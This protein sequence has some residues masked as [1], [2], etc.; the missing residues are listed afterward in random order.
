VEAG[1]GGAA[2]AADLLRDVDSDEGRARMRRAAVALQR[3]V[4]EGPKKPVARRADELSKIFVDAQ[5]GARYAGNERCLRCHRAYGEEGRG[6]LF[7][8]YALSPRILVNARRGCEGC[9]G[10]GSKHVDGTIEA[11]TNPR[12]LTKQGQADLCFSCHTVAMLAGDRELHFPG[13]GSNHV[14]CLNCHRVHSPA[15]EKNLREEPNRLCMKCHQD[16][17]AEFGLRSRHPVRPEEP[18]PLFSV[19]EGKVRCIDCHRAYSRRRDPTG[20]EP[21]VE[22]CQGCHA[23]TRGPFLFSHDA[24][25]AEMVDGCGACHLAHGS[26]NRHLLRA[27]GRS[28]CVTCHTDFSAAHFPGQN[29]SSCHRDI[30]GSNTSHIFLR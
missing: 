28:L 29:C 14:T 15:A 27:T 1:R 21:T 7:A 18:T 6:S 23:D 20:R 11:I 5:R 10:P 22:T 16:V 30:H 8:L 3:R 25:S 17:L 24:G 26:P 9:H 2:S 12:R 4:G 13:H 19:R